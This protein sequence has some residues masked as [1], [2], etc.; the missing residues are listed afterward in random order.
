M[1]NTV[2]VTRHPALV[3]LLVEKGV[4]EPGTPVLSHAGASDVEGKHV[5]G[6]LPLQLSA[7]A[8]SITEVPLRLSPED[9]GVELTLERLKEIAGEPVTYQVTKVPRQ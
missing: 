8:L 1:N 5:V 7:L 3:T 6:V 4:I 2:V 9:R